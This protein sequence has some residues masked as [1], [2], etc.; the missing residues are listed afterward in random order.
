MTLLSPFHTSNNIEATFS[1]AT[2]RLIL[3][4]KSEVQCCFDIFGVFDNSV[5]TFGNN[6]ERS[7]VLSTKSKKLSMFNLFRTSVSVEKTKF[8]EKL[9][10]HCCH[11]GNNVE[12]TFD[13]VASTLLLV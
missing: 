3:S 8:H 9:V 13:F 10:R 7:F 4:T 1:N 5:A 2:S 11:F 6:V 12:A